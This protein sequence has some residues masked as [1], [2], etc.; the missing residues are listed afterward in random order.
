MPISYA[1]K[2][3]IEGA[4]KRVAIIDIGSNSVRLVVYHGTKRIPLP[5][6]NEKYM[7]ALGKGLARTGRLN[8]K[9]AQEAQKVIARFILMARRMEV[10]SLDILATAAVRD[11]SD[12][13]DFVRSIEKAHR[14]KVQVL[15]GER[16]ARLAA[17]GILTS[18]HEPE[19]ISADLGGGSM[20][21]AELMRT[22][23]GRA[24]S[25][26][27][28]SLRLF[29]E[30][31][32]KTAQM[33]RII[34]RRFAEVEWLEDAD[35]PMLYAIG[36]G[37]RT[38]AKLHMKK[39]HYP[40]PIVHEYQISRR[41]VIQATEKLLAMKVDEVAALP[42]VSAKRAPLMVPTALMLRGLMQHAGISQ[43]MFSVS[44]IREG[45]FYDM[46]DPGV[47]AED[48][49]IAS[50]TDLALLVGLTGAYAKELFVWMQPLFVQ[51]PFA[52]RRL[53][54]ASAI[55]S[56]IAWSIDP[57]FR[58]VWAYHRIIQSSLK[59]M[60]HKERI[61]LALAIYHRYQSKWKGSRAEHGL[62]D[63]RA[64]LWA[65]VAGLAASL[66]FD[67]T[68]GKPGTLHHATLSVQQGDV[69]LELDEEAAPLYTD[70]VQKRLEG[71]G[72]AYR[73]FSMAT[74]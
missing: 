74:V 10:E 28:G 32:G 13:A 58:G 14:I 25:M 12:G 61:M 71:L 1:A 18:V 9:G 42:G 73:A 3:A 45:F 23:V 17:Q 26:Q 40:L 41:S 37:F 7:C 56:E 49:L 11:A 67:L 19:G 38:L 5:L 24:A 8:P 55:L 59:G 69:V 29:E 34:A 48:G 63:E 64:R 46:L 51:E 50:A 53:R 22:K 36:G 30:S 65:K 47:Q 66:A 54:E 21:V 70:I 43:V 68:G 31:E 52:W 39:T 44:G 60:D 6:F 27:L 72:E 2:L 33:E 15:P 16:E 57:N 20:E 4:S 62:L 35:V